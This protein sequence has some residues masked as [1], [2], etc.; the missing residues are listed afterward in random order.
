LVFITYYV[1]IFGNLTNLKTLLAYLLPILNFP[2][3]T[4]P[5]WGRVYYKQSG[6]ELA[7]SHHVPAADAYGGVRKTIAAI[8]ACLPAIPGAR[9]R[10]LWSIPGSA[11][12]VWR[13]FRGS[14]AQVFAHTRHH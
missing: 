13:K 4:L 11:A 3:H 9:W 2:L 6:G 5:A 7:S 1:C 14:S 8:F 10:A 12:Q